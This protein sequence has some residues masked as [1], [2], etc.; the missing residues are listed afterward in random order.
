MKAKSAS[1]D[2]ISALLEIMLHPKERVPE[3]SLSSLQWFMGGYGIGT[4]IS[5][6][7]LRNDW[8]L[9]SKFERQVHENTH[10]NGTVYE[11]FYLEGYSDQESWDSMRNALHRFVAEEEIKPIAHW[12]KSHST[13]R[14]KLD[15]FLRSAIERP[16]MILGAISLP[17]LSRW[18]DGIFFAIRRHSNDP[19]IEQMMAHFDQWVHPNASGRPLIRWNRRLLY[20]SGFNEERAFYNFADAYNSF[21]KQYQWDLNP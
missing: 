14:R 15:A 1:L 6:I 16:V 7:E 2:Y 12:E 5:G 19:A 17:R 11:C 4:S 9:W 21:S 18:L 20:N 8:E 10:I 13:D 3:K